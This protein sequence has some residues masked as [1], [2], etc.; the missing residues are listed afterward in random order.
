[1]YNQPERETPMAWPLLFTVAAAAGPARAAPHRHALVIG[2]N[3]PGPEQSALVYAQRDAERIAAVLE[4]LGGFEAGDVEVLR[5][6]GVSEVERAIER[7]TA[8]VQ[9]DAARD[10]ESMALFYYSGHARSQALDLGDDALALP[11]LRAKLEA[12]PATVRVVVLDACQTGAFSQVKGAEPAAMFSW[13]SVNELSAEGLAVLASSTGAELSQES[14]EIGGSYF[15]HHL[16]SGLRGAADRDG[17]GAVTLAEAYDYARDRTLVATARTAVGR[18]HVTLETELKGR[19]ELVL[20]RPARATAHLEL[21]SAVQGELLIHRDEVVLAEVSKGRGSALR[22]ALPPGAYE[23]ILRDR[24]RAYE[25]SFTLRAGATSPFDPTACAQI[26]M[27]PADA[28][29]RERARWIVEGTLGVL[30]IRDDAYVETIEDFGFETLSG[31]A[32]PTLTVAAGLHWNPRLELVAGL[33]ALDLRSWRRD[34]ID[35]AEGG[36]AEEDNFAYTVWRLGLYGRARAPLARGTVVPYLQAG[37]GPTIGWTRWS[38]PEGALGEAFVGY[39]L[40]AAAGAGL[41]LTRGFG[42]FAQLES[43]Y[44]PTVKN[45][46]G[47]THDAGGLGVTLGVRIGR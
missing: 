19:D 37:L 41:Q 39:H 1:V 13:Q 5:D 7:L 44:A 31:G 30:G 20:T 18:Q 8:R 11:E 43:V 40:A 38:D 34:R 22:L 28:K 16:V 21:T 4:E 35:D 47:D 10:E 33:G 14:P 23:A 12:I 17:D 24:G 46:V 27:A 15:T 26:P 6:P 3:R 45:L 29:G 36:G 9:D 25:C 42:T 32:V 2:S